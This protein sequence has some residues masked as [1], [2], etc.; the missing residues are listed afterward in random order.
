MQERGVSEEDACA[1]V[2]DADVTYDDPD[3][4][5]CRVKTINGRRIRVVLLN[6]DPSFVKTVVVESA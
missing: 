6:S 4:N 2:D 3:G 5:P 1:V